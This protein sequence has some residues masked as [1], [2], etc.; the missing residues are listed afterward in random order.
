MGTLKRFGVP[1]NKQV[2]ITHTF[3]MKTTYIYLGVIAILMWNG[4]AIRRD[5][6]LW[7]SYKQTKAHLE[8]CQAFPTNSSCKK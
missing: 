3:Q 2:I 7:K 8:Y 5:N 4:W 1:Y 6:E